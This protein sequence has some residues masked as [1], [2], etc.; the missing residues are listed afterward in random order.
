MWNHSSLREKLVPGYLIV[1]CNIHEREILSKVGLFVCEAHPISI[2][3]DER[4]PWDHC[5]NV[6]KECNKHPIMGPTTIGRHCEVVIKFVH[7]NHD[8]NL[9]RLW[10]HCEFIIHW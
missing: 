1:M 2:L 6:C 9:I 7:R 10:V 3:T 4:L 8:M 5:Q